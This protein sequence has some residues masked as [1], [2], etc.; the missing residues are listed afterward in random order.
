MLVSHRK[1]F[2]YLKTIKTA[3]TSVESFFEPY[4]FP[5][6]EWTFEKFRPETESDSGIVGF[7]GVKKKTWLGIQRHRWFDHMHAKTVKKQLPQATWDS[8]FKF[9]VVRN[10]FD[11]AISAFHFFA[12]MQERGFHKME[13]AKQEDE[14]VWFRNWVKAC[15]A[16]RKQVFDRP[17]YTIDEKV[18]VDFFIRYENLKDDLLSVCQRLDI[19]PELDRLPELVGGVRPESRTIAEYYD[20][21]TIKI[22]ERVFDFEL[23]RF[24][25]EMP[26]G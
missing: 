25:Y 12:W 5:E 4:C 6:G 20:E 11:K 26:K 17:I 1:Q 21:P 8:Y 22:I 14:V 13:A 9:C 10:P 16:N 15:V 2:I 19:E 24:G 7:R 18:C 23:E 3:S